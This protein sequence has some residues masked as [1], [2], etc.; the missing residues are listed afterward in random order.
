MIMETRMEAREVAGNADR[1]KGGIR[2]AVLSYHGITDAAGSCDS[3]GAVPGRRYHI[4]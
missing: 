2:Y 1:V 4:N 3:G